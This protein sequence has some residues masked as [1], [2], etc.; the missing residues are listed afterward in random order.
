ML[1]WK[2]LDFL[3]IMDETPLVNG[4][5]ISDQTC[6]SDKSMIHELEQKGYGEI[7][8]KKLFLQ[9]FETLYLLYTK[10]LILKKEKSI[11]ILILS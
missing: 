8:N 11:L 6:I 1:I 10:K 7:E 5:L 2:F 3:F 9:E 4:Q